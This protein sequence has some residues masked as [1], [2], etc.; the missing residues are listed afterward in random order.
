VTSRR[1]CL[2]LGPGPEAAA[3][4][5]EALQALRMRDPGGPWVADL[6]AELLARTDLA[7]DDARPSAWFETG[8]WAAN[9]IP[10]TRATEW[11]GGR[12]TPEPDTDVEPELLLS[13]PG[14]VWFLGLWKA[15]AM[16]CGATPVSLHVLAHPAACAASA[17]DALPAVA[18]W[19][20]LVLHGERATR[21]TERA[22]VT[23]A[24]VLADWTVPVFAA[25][26]ALGLRSVA[27]ASANDMRRVHQVLGGEAARMAGVR[28][29]WSDLS[30]PAPVADLAEAVWSALSGLA[31][32]GDP[33]AGPSAAEPTPEV[34]AGLE[35]LRL[36]Y[37]GMYEDAE[38]LTAST[39][40]AAARSSGR[41]VE[42]GDPAALQARGLKR[43]LGR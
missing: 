35:E 17:P 41:E 10:R 3:T 24:D 18:S 7:V 29:T 28:P 8:K 21:G 40:R 4:V 9:G 14:L 43:L 42:S 6:H 19:L 15:A 23:F 34:E 26:R 36:A 25:G 1:V 12:F 38:R 30:V 32:V 5:A 39:A 31:V 37:V 33:S 2:V 20:N 11:L 22:F 16:R 27:E 13:D